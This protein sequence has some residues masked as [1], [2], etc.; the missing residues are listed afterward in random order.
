M[1]R[2]SLVALLLF[3]SGCVSNIRKIDICIL[4]VKTDIADCARGEEVYKKKV[5]ELKFWH[6]MDT[7]S[8]EQLAAKLA[9]CDVNKK[10]PKE[11]VFYSLE[12]CDISGDGTMV[13][14]QLKGIISTYEL[15]HVDG[16]IATDE[17]GL[18]KIKAKLDFCMKDA[19]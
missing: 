19:R 11:D 15:M 16:Y 2:A 4:D 18:K 5:S 12:I 10:L 8:Y 14:C 13:F 9:E 3:I 17:S 7:V 1:A 6:A